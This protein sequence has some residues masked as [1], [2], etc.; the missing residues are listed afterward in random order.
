MSKRVLILL[1]VG[2]LAIVA[3]V[4][5]LKYELTK[6]EQEQEPG[7]NN[8]PVAEKFTGGRKG[9]Y[10]DRNLKRYV[11][12]KPKPGPEAQ[13]GGSDSIALG[14]IVDSPLPGAVKTT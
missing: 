8:K 3:A 1:L 4:F 13:K 6:P 5:L 12:S 11:A 9:F 2:I 14:E 7:E 10:Y